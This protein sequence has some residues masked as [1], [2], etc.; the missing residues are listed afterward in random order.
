MLETVEGF[1]LRWVGVVIEG[2]MRDPCARIVSVLTLVWIHKPTNMIKL[3]GLNC[4]ETKQRLL[5]QS[6]GG[7]KCSTQR[8]PLQSNSEDYAT[9]E[10]TNDQHSLHGSP[11]EFTSFHPIGIPVCRCQLPESLPA[12][13]PPPNLQEPRNCINSQQAI[14]CLESTL[15]SIS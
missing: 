3:Y 7:S 12:P 2:D 4:K 5:I 14:S 9:E 6:C 1:I 11:A 15:P 13:S 8:L 10:G